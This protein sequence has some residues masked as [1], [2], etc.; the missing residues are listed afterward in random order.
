[1]WISCTS[2]EKTGVYNFDRI[3]T[4]VTQVMPIII[5]I[6]EYYPNL[7]YCKHDNQ[8]GSYR[9]DVREVID[10]AIADQVAKKNVI[11]PTSKPGLQKK[12]LKG[13]GIQLRVQS[14]QARGVLNVAQRLF[15]ELR[16][17]KQE[18]KEAA[19][20]ERLKAAAQRRIILPNVEDRVA[21]SL[22]H[23]VYNHGAL[24]YDDAEHL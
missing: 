23:W 14:L 12:D 2:G 9:Q 3:N 19:E 1:M 11:A 21:K 16:Q 5:R 8:V 10:E 20:T 18:E 17:I 24:T 22:V 13:M 4:D 15:D 7:T 6:Y